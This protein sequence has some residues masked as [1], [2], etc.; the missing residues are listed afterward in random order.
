M[1][2]ILTA[3]IIAAI[4]FVVTGCGPGEPFEIENLNANESVT[5]TQVEAAR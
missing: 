5:I 1:K 3:A 4:L 2:T